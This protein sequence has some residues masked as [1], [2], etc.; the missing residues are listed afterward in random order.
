MNDWKPLNWELAVQARKLEV[1]FFKKMDGRVQ[2][3]T[4]RR[5]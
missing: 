2:G 5:C 3:R 1:E 4:S